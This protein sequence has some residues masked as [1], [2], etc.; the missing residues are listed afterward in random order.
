MKNIIKL[1]SFVVAL[2]FSCLSVVGCAESGKYEYYVIEN[3]SYGEY[4]ERSLYDAAFPKGVEKAPIILFIHGGGWTA[5]SKDGA[6]KGFVKNSADGYIYVALNYRYIGDGVTCYD[7]LDDI[8]ACLVSVKKDA[9]KLGV[10]V[11]KMMI[12]GYSA[13]GHLSLM[14]AYK[15][16]DESP[17]EVGMV[18]SYSGVTD[19]NDENYYLNEKYFCPK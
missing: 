10:E 11:G 18:A 9:E 7:I 2:I 16:A 6:V 1:L 8:T 12:Y 17:F 4:G 19:L 15:M 14:Y 3:A 5:G 13:G